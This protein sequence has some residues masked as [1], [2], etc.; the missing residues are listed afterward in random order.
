MKIYTENKENILVSFLKNWRKFESK[1]LIVEV[2]AA[3]YYF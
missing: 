1:N 2:N 3:I